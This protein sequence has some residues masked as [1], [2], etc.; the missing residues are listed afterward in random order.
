MLTK[1]CENVPAEVKVKSPGH[2][3]NAIEL[4]RF[5]PSKHLRQARGPNGEYCCS[6]LACSRTFL[7]SKK[8]SIH[9]HIIHKPRALCIAGC[10][11]LRRCQLI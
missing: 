2:V 9:I 4:L 5:T 3:I 10:E 8:L 7:T 11:G 1:D 6:W